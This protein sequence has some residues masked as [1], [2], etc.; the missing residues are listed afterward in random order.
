MR[1][2][3][4]IQA[5]KSQVDDPKIKSEAPKDAKPKKGSRKADKTEKKDA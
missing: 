1:A 3:A 4:R 2:S 5:Q